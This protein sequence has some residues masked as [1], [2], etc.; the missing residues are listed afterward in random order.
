MHREEFESSTD[1]DDDHEP[2]IEDED[3]HDDMQAIIHDHYTASTINE[4]A[5]EDSTSNGNVV[6]DWK[7]D[8]LMRL[9][10]DAK[11][12][13]YPGCKTFSKLSFIVKPLYLKIF[14]HWSR[15]SFTMLPE[16]LQEALLDGEM[17]PS[18]FYEAKNIIRNLGLDYVRICACKNDWVLF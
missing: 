13:L 3:D 1:E 11:L 2:N 14:N 7:A 4:W 10:K 8:K 5:G 18:S 16:L 9:L 15:K 17:L 6:L 12:K